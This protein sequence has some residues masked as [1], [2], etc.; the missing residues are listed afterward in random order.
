MWLGGRAGGFL[1]GVLFPNRAAGHGGKQHS[2]QQNRAREREE[3]SL[4]VWLPNVAEQARFRWLQVL[5]DITKLPLV[6]FLNYQDGRELDDQGRNQVDCRN[7]QNPGLERNREVDEIEGLP[8]RGEGI[9][10]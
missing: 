1:C 10:A 4:T 3:N 9:T 6:N 7:P 8:G 5:A 2:H